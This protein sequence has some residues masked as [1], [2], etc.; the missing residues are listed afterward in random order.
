MFVRLGSYVWS[1]GFE[2]LADRV[3]TLWSIGFSCSV[4]RIRM[5]GR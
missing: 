4:D 1:I 2:C 5:L 3:C